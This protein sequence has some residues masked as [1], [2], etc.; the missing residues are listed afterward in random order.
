MIGLG[1]PY[2]KG[3]SGVYIHGGSM[4]TAA[5]NAF[6]GLIRD[7]GF[8]F[9]EPRDRDNFTIGKYRMHASISSSSTSIVYIGLVEV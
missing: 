8:T 4:E 3:K 7:D 1:V 5:E 2:A 9:D 6:N